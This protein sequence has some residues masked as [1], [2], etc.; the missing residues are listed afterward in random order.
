[1]HATLLAAVV[2]VVLIAGAYIVGDARQ[3]TLRVDAEAQVA[4]LEARAARAE[5]RVR[6][7]ELLGRV[8]TVREAVVGQNYGQ[9]LEQS[10][11]FFDAV[12]AEAGATPEP[13]LREALTE[14]LASRDLVT[15]ALAKS[16]PGV[17]ETLNRLELRLR[18]A[19]GY[20]IPPDPVAPVNPG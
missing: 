20:A 11:L 10:S 4:A 12:R 18:R 5:A 2:V 7:G 13:G 19:L 3:R 8:L 1:M 15:A 9:A 16:D 14:V 17:L 6:T